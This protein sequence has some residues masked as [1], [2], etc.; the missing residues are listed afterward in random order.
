MIQ[1]T[2]IIQEIAKSSDQT[3]AEVKG[4]LDAFLLILRGDEPVQI[5]NFGTF[6]HVTRKP[7]VGRNPRTGQIHSIPERRVL[8]FKAAKAR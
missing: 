1:Y 7:K 6:K 8:R 4:I 5:R 2:D 3:Q